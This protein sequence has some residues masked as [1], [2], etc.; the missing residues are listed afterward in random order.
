[1]S[2]RG[3]AA[4]LRRQYRAIEG[5]RSLSALPP[6]LAPER[7]EMLGRRGGPLPREWVL[8]AKD[9]LAELQVGSL[10]LGPVL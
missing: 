7:P 4:Q 3:K 2:G 8:V 9:E 1:M 10:P 6:H 5:A